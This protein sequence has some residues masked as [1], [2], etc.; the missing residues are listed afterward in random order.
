MHYL[1][2][3]LVWIVGLGCVEGRAGITRYQPAESW[4]AAQMSPDT[5]S[6]SGVRAERIV[7]MITSVGGSMERSVTSWTFLVP[8]PLSNITTLKELEVPPI[9]SHNTS[10]ENMNK[11]EAK[12]LYDLEHT[13]ARAK[14]AAKREWDEVKQWK[15]ELIYD[16]RYE[17]VKEIRASEKFVKELRN[18]LV[19]NSLM[20]YDS[21]N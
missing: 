10:M 3:I 19:M 18:E 21:I 20:D 11:I 2:L 16:L 9:R 15:G 14:I 7:S 4:K 12:R 5:Y 17:T 13:L 8:E 1:I 6:I